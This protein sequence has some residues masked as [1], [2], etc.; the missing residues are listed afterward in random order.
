MRG[1]SVA[2][3]SAWH[4]ASLVCSG[5][6]SSARAHFG[7]RRGSKLESLCPPGF[8]FKWMG[9]LARSSRPLLVSGPFTDQPLRPALYICSMLS[10]LCSCALR[11][12]RGPGTT[13]LAA[14]QRASTLRRT[15][16]PPRRRSG[17][18]S[19][20]RCGESSAQSSPRLPHATA[21]LA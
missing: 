10:A 17:S 12:P 11:L 5:Q 4:E 16:K 9:Y 14:G 13:H 7:G 18:A 6:P 15:S 21:A 19:L 8:A 20:G 1:D 3:A 2:A